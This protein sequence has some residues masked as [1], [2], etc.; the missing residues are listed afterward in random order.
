M[1]AD[2]LYEPLLQ[3]AI[4]MVCLSVKESE[5]EKLMGPLPGSAGTFCCLCFGVTYQH[6]LQ[7]S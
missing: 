7:Q 3:Q 5:L 2:A 6:A 1:G 4:N